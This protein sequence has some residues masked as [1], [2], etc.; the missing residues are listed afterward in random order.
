VS[1]TETEHLHSDAK[2]SSGCKQLNFTVTTY[3]MEQQIAVVLWSALRRRYT[4]LR[5]GKPGDIN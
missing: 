1:R 4:L 3:Q 5:S 2:R